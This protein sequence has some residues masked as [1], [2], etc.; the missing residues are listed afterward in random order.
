MVVEIEFKQ[1][2]LW[3]LTNGEYEHKFQQMTQG[4]KK[5]LKNIF[6]PLEFVQK[7]FHF[8]NNLPNI[9]KMDEIS[10]ELAQH[11]IFFRLRFLQLGAGEITDAHGFL[12]QHGKTA[13]PRKIPE[14]RKHF[15]SQVVMKS[16]KM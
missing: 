3:T 7:L 13:E 1:T 11:L 6:A 8:H 15:P 2:K 4:V 12:T 10:I 9:D 16:W 14:W 5:S